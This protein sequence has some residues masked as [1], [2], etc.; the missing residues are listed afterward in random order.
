M[1]E[2]LEMLIPNTKTKADAFSKEYSTVSLALEG[3]SRRIMQ[4]PLTSAICLHIARSHAALVGRGGGAPPGGRSSSI[5]A[6]ARRLGRTRITPFT[7][8][9][10]Q[11]V[12]DQ[13]RGM[14]E[15]T[16]LL[17]VSA[18]KV[19]EIRSMSATTADLRLDRAMGS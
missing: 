1:L 6:I 5:K 3:I 4:L 16:R 18:A 11:S 19:S 9:R 2:I 7:V 14:S 10:I 17:K 13:G 8:Q 15:T 12:L